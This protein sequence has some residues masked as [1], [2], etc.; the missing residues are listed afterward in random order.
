MGGCEPTAEVAQPPGIDPLVETT[1]PAPTPS[2]V[3]TITA[4]PSLLEVTVRPNP[5]DEPTSLPAATAVPQTPTPST[6]T[7][8]I[9]P[10]DTLLGLALARGIELSE[11]Q[12][13]NP[14]VRAEA[15]QIGQQIVVP[16]APSVA[17]TDS[18][19]AGGGTLVAGDP[20]VVAADPGLWVFGQVTSESDVALAPAQLTLT[21][22]GAD[23]VELTSASAWTAGRRIDARGT[24]PYAF[25]FPDL[26]D[27]GLVARVDIVAPGLAGVPVWPDLSATD[28][29]VAAEDGATDISGRLVNGG[30]ETVTDLLLTVTFYDDAGVYTGYRQLELPGAL[31]PDASLP[32]QMA[33]LPIRSTVDSVTIQIDARPAE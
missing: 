32:F 5:V 16:A 2:P 11:L 33:A 19:E 12:A 17:P 6:E 10:G 31:T 29:V 28:V 23:D 18:G 1:E 13:L 30:D 22:L 27:D 3:A 14:D 15:L 26:S 4:T 7:Y 25:Y 9:Q 8:A 24:A 21:L 20:Q